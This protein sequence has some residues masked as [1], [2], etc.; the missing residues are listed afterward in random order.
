MNL[1]AQAMGSFYV[2][3]HKLRFNFLNYYERF[4]KQHSLEGNSHLAMSLAAFKSFIGS[5]Y[6]SAT[7]ITENLCLRV[8]QYLLDKCSGET[9][10]NY[11]HRFKRV[12]R[13]AAKEGYFRVSPSEDIKAKTNKNSQAKDILESAEYYKLLKTPCKNYEV[14]KAFIFS[15]YTGVRWVNVKQ[16]KWENI[17]EQDPNL[18]PCPAKNRRFF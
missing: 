1:D 17:K 4:V 14:Q 3:R 11:F 8:R 6:I 2:C 5:S 10:S 13:A 18:L 12:L 9:P 15:L 16:M 7:D